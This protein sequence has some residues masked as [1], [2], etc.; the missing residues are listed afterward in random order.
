[1]QSK[2]IILS[3][4]AC[5]MLGLFAPPAEALPNPVVQYDSIMEAE[6]A[7]HVVASAP[8][9]L[10][11]GYSLASVS[12]I[13]NKVLQVIYKNPADS[14]VCYRVAL[15]TGDISGLYGE[16][17]TKTLDI[18]GM[19]VT[20]KWDKGGIILAMWTHAEQTYSVYFEEPVDLDFI[21]RFIQSL[22]PAL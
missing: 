2:L 4:A 3:F 15:G 9:I 22:P 7:T 18:A 17:E 13:D 21:T 8:T 16:Y 20:T 6:A 12:A 11:P 14:Q 10:P 19:P 1:M 5:V